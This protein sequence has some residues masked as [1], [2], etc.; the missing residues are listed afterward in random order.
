MMDFETF[1]GSRTGD[2]SHH[3]DDF[4]AESFYHHIDAG[5]LYESLQSLGEDA[6]EFFHGES[7]RLNIVYIAEADKAPL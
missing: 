7:C 4:A 6:I 5:A 3:P 1:V 2:R